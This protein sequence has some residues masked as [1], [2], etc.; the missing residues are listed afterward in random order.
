MIS[1]FR[2]IPRKDRVILALDCDLDEAVRIATQVR[3]CVKWVKV[4]MT[5]FY[6][7]GPIAVKTF[8]D[9]GF[10]VFLDL[11]FH[12]IPYQVYGAA[13]SATLS[14]ANMLSMHCVG[15][16]AMLNSAQRG[17]E[18]AA[19]FLGIK[20]PA[21]LGITVLTSMNQEELDITGVSRPV[22][23]QVVS[24]AMLADNSAL[25][26]VVASVHE[27]LVLRQFLGADAHI[28]T[29]GIRLENAS[30]DDQSRVATPTMAFD[31]GASH[32]VIGRPITGAKDPLSA[33]NEIFANL[34]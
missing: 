24:L 3:G 10:R 23:E 29:P 25:S 15:G 18:E 9:L 28:V 30:H 13:Y 11:K 27:T 31:S 8:K 1:K 22:A 12:D 34:D 5:M 4:G 19:D 32:I 33:A 16:A 17:V 6:K 7:Y 2:D 20:P 14:G 26:G 21:T